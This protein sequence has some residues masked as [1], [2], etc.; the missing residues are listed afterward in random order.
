MD[1]EWVEGSVARLRSMQE[2]RS[3]TTLLEKFAEELANI[4]GCGKGVLDFT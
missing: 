3:G 1:R 4:N 2:R